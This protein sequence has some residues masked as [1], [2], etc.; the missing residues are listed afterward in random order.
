LSARLTTLLC[1]KK[2]VAKSNEVITGWRTNL[3]ESSKEVAQRGCFASD[4]VGDNYAATLN[5][6]SDEIRII[7]RLNPHNHFS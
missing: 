2:T 5:V 3:A 4:D 1:K 6:F 7:V